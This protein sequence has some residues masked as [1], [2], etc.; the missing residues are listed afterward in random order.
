ML[1]ASTDPQPPAYK[2]H[3]ANLHEEFK[4]IICD[5]LLP[6]LPPVCRLRDGRILEHAIPLKPTAR[7]EAKQPYRLSETEV[8]EL[9]TQITTLVN[10]GWI[11]PSLSPWGAPVFLQ[12]K[13]DGKPY[14]CIDYR[15]L[16]HHTVKHAYPMPASRNSFRNSELTQLSHSLT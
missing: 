12:R 9:H 15:A 10:Q 4:D 14:M 6:G 2:Q 5:N 8:T 13:M 11:R 1:A 16:N 3:E 7:P